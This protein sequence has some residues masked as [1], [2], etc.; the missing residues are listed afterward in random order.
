MR[1]HQKQ[2]TFAIERTPSYP[3]PSNMIHFT[4]A[5]TTQ[6]EFLRDSADTL[7]VCNI[8]INIALAQ[9]RQAES[10]IQNMIAGNI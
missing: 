10:E 4:L 7:D 2:E 5:Q 9:I 3:A 1:I 8:I 6:A